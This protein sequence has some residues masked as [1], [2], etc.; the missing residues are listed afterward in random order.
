M[1]QGVTCQSIASTVLQDNVPVHTL[2]L[3]FGKDRIDVRSNSAE[4][5]AKLANYYRDFL[6]GEGQA[7]IAVTAIEADTP[8]LPVALA[9]KRPEPGKTRIKEE[10][11][12][13]PDG[14]VVRKVLT[15]MVFLFGGPDNLAVGPCLANDNQVV[16]FINNRYIEHVIKAGA[17]L[18]HA[19]GVAVKGRGLTIAGF[20][21]AGKSTLSL[22]IMRLG[23]DFVSNDRMMVSRENNRLVMRGIPKM[24]RINPGTVLHNESLGPVMNAEERERFSKL[25]PAELW[26]L[27]HKYDAFIDECFG[28]GK[29]KL[30]AD[31]A[32]LA[33]LHW[34]RD[35]SPLHVERVDLRARRDLAQAFM[36]DVGLFFEMDDPAARLDFSQDAYLD[37][38]GDCPVFEF[39]GG[40]HFAEAARFC[41]DFLE[42]RGE[43]ERS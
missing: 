30:K 23:P 31:M 1:T 34:R 42:A 33:I 21:G 25:P 26:D 2:K 39:T 37:L 11:A 5:V 4:L 27:E 17:L 24:P 18:F 29:F 3:A 8:G 13:L 16:N 19:A 6:G 40:V 43:A 14:R 28:P 35:D 7:I 22:E 32:G 9:I 36:K 12:D 10:F 15:G 20:A 41:M 38:L